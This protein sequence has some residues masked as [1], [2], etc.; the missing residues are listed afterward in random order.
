MHHELTALDFVIRLGVGAGLGV[1]IG[2]ERQWRHRAAGL[3]TSGLVAIGAT[4]FALLDAAISA[5]DTTRVLAG[6]VSGVGFIAAGVILRDGTNVSGLNTAATIWATAAVGALA[7]LG[8]FEEAAIAAAVIIVLNVLMQPI[9]ERIDYRSKHRKNRET[10]YKLS[11]VCD[12]KQ[13]SPVRGTIVAAV[14]DSPLSLQALTRRNAD[15]GNVEIDAD[16]FSK[17]PDES[18]IERLVTNLAS[19]PGVVTSDWRSVDA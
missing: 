19:L 2:F 5:S 6:I 15:G 12:A 10:I 1:A 8:F 17:K 4:L 13:Q 9:A 18:T 11:V 14:T 16:L 7:G 3:H